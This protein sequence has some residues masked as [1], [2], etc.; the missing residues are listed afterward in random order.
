MIGLYLVCVLGGSVYSVKRY[1]Q[2]QVY[3]LNPTLMQPVKAFHI[4]FDHA[5]RLKDGAL[6]VIL[7]Q[8]QQ[9][10]LLAANIHH[11]VLIDDLSHFYQSR[12]YNPAKTADFGYGS[13]G[14]Y[15]TFEE[16]QYHIQD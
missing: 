3:H 7:S 13:M 9:Q 14:G 8:K 2:V 4:D 15:F 1:Q 12:L 5:Q 10:Q 11:D 16:I 6:T